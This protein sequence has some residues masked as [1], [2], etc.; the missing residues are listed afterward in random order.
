[1]LE[2]EEA[3]D[4]VPVF[5]IA[6]EVLDNLPHDKLVWRPDA[7]GEWRRAAFLRTRSR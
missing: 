3:G 1:M 4:A 2:E 5:A 6:L 7:T